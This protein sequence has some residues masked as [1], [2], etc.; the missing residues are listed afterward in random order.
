MAP[1]N[2]GS[3]ADPVLLR[4]P[5]ITGCRFAAADYQQIK[6]AALDERECFEE[7]R[8]ALEVMRPVQR[9]HER[10]Q[11]VVRGKPQF[12]AHRPLARERAEQIG[13]HPVWNL[14]HILPSPP[15]QGRP[16][17]GTGVILRQNFQFP[18]A[19]QH[20]AVGH[21][22][23]RAEEEPPDP[24][25]DQVVV[26][27][28]D[29]RD[30]PDSRDRANEFGAEDERIV[31][32]D[33]VE[34]PDS[35]QARQERCVPEPHRGAQPPDFNAGRV[36]RLRLR[37]GGGIDRHPMP[38]PGQSQRVVIADIPRAGHIRRKRGRHMCNPHAAP[39]MPTRFPGSS[40]PDQNQRDPAQ[41]KENGIE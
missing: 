13:V 2:N 10:H 6:V 40:P 4:L 35:D 27:R 18:R 5:T 22:R 32:V 21:R 15:E 19:A 38:E 34:V 23:I 41:E 33:D 29:Q 11:P 17:A 7:G 28:Q 25:P 39:S 37:T 26:I 36:E 24:F 8:H 14:D 12:L 1:V 16:K 31:Q 9:S 20:Q 3:P 30:P